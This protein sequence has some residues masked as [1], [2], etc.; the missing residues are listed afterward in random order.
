MAEPPTLG[1][2]RTAAF[3]DLDALAENFRAIGNVS[4]KEVLPIIKADAYGHGA[5]EAARTLVRAGARALG[6]AAVEEGEALRRGR[7]S[8]LGGDIGNVPIIVLS[9][10]APW[11]AGRL[12]AAG[13]EAVVWSA[14]QVEALGAAAR[15]AGTVVRVH[16]KVD[17][18]MG[19]LGIVP[20]EAAGFI[21][22]AG[23]ETGI[24]VASLMSHLAVA[25]EE[26]GQ[27]PT[28][29]Q[30]DAFQ[31][32]AD[33][34]RAEGLCPPELHCANSAGAL[35]YPDAPG[36]WVRPGIALYGC[37]PAGAEEVPL[38]PVM[39]WRGAIIQ[40]KD[41]AARAPVGYGATYRR[42][43]PGRIAVVSAGYADGYPR[44]LSNRADAIV[45]GQ[46]APLAGRV[47]MDMLALDV[48]HIEGAAAGDAATLLGADGG[49]RIPAE[50]LA[51]RAHT[52]SYEVLCG[53]SARVPRVFVEGG[54]VVGER[55]LGGG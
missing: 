22:M 38:R 2:R 27:A 50:E 53:V 26:E 5:A 14:A 16:V 18:G 37:P 12:I 52:I 13:L 41:I 51:V 34:L 24:E 49:E 32:L 39:T 1:T 48:T 36:G 47:S 29:A 11:A 21:Q 7:P 40:V 45:R 20:A 43:S 17:T 44:I 31:A 9:G 6:V 19:R 46:R 23:K 28:R 42:Q 25:D 15:A 4:G 55:F 33:D 8:A 54:E 35:L 10:G 3:I 30:F